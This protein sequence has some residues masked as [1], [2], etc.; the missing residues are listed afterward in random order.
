MRI[1]SHFWLGILAGLLA[2]SASLF[3]IFALHGFHLTGIAV[4]GKTILLATAAWSAAF[5]LV[6]RGE[7]FAFRGYLQFTFT[8]GMASGRP[9]FC[10]KA[11]LA[12]KPYCPHLRCSI[13]LII[14]AA[15]PVKRKIDP[16]L[17]AAQ[18]A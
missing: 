4:H 15:R 3:A 10:S 17:R 7:E 9:R 2:I 18:W 1:H 14:S 11:N 12:G 5:V 13:R 6:G 16:S 8:T